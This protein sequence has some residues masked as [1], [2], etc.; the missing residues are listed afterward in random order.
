M[1]QAGLQNV[2]TLY[3]QETWRVARSWESLDLDIESVR[4]AWWGE[5]TMFSQAA[6]CLSLS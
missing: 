2:A 5:L 3:E 1:G 6:S 4:V